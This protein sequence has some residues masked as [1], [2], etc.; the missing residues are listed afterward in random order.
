[1]RNVKAKNLYTKKLEWELIES[2]Y[3][4]ISMFSNTA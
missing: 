4:Y 1:M 3:M 2:V